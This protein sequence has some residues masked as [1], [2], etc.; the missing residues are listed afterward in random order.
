MTRG[1]TARTVKSLASITLIV[2][3][4]ISSAGCAKKQESISNKRLFPEEKGI[5]V[6]SGLK[7]FL[8]DPKTGQSKELIPT[9]K[10]IS[11]I[12]Y[13]S[14]EKNL[15]VHSQDGKIYVCKS[16]GSQLKTT[17]IKQAENHLLFPSP[18]LSKIAIVK[19]ADDKTRIYVRDLDNKEQ[20]LITKGDCSFISWSPNNTTIYFL[21]GGSSFLSDFRQAGQATTLSICLGHNL[22]WSV[23][24][25]QTVAE[26]TRNGITQIAV[27]NL[28]FGQVRDVTSKIQLL[29]P[30]TGSELEPSL[31]ALSP[32][33]EKVAFCASDT[34]EWHVFSLVL[35]NC[36]LKIVSPAKRDFEV[37]TRPSRPFWSPDNKKIAFVDGNFIDGYKLYIA[38]AQREVG[39]QKIY[40]L[41]FKR[42]RA[43]ADIKPGSDS[44]F[45]I[46][47]IISWQ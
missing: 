34:A 37:V 41:P 2:S 23:D 12:F 16:D 22:D 44:S 18:D 46:P 6:V 26:I 33:G 7:F 36:L 13:R 3:L 43:G 45:Y 21:K 29:S 27:A 35:K 24:G 4:L 47:Y 5:I 25:K 32:D 8:I 38:E 28:N 11:R 30:I 15:V 40:N 42:V 17:D 10:K 1:K 9:V 19:L 14:Q 31:P 39:Q 20:K